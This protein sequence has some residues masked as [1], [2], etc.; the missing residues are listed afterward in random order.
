VVK[1]Y[2]LVGLEDCSGR[3]GNEGGRDEGRWDL[4]WRPEL[5]SSF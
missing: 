3:R 2:G 5:I 1:G 4:G